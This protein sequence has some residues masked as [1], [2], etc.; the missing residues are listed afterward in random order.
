MIRLKISITE[1][2]AHLASYF[3]YNLDWAK[4]YQILFDKICNGNVN[5]FEVISIFA[6]IPNEIDYKDPTYSY[7]ESL[8]PN[9]LHRNLD[10]LEYTVESLVEEYYLGI[11]NIIKYLRLDIDNDYLFIKMYDKTTALIEI[12]RRDNFKFNERQEWHFMSHLT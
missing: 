4:K 10:F 7:I 1:S 11:E 3:L 2:D 5:V 9:A 6:K 12:V 8:C